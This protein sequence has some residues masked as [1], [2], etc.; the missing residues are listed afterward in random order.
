[1]K[2]ISS[3]RS[4]DVSEK[5]FVSFLKFCY[6]DIADKGM[7]LYMAHR[8]STARLTSCEYDLVIPTFFDGYLKLKRVFLICFD[9]FPT[10]IQY[11]AVFSPIYYRNNICD[12]GTK[13]ISAECDKFLDFLLANL[14]EF[15]KSRIT[16]WS[17]GCAVGK[18]YATID[19]ICRTVQGKINFSN[20]E[21]STTTPEVIIIVCP[22]VSLCKQFHQKM[23][24]KVIV[25][26]YLD[27]EEV[28]HEL[29]LQTL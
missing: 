18:S 7:S 6:S 5:E 11:Q 2:Y 10:Q 14:E 27:K 12:Q 17:A 9:D 19:T 21:W 15:T 4:A 22:T 28:T 1:M 25:K 3:L 23:S 26:I 8:T 29:D 13:K 20:S 24:E 16:A